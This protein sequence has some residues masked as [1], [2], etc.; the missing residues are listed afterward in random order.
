MGNGE[1]SG[2]GEYSPRGAFPP[3]QPW[4]MRLWV[5]SGLGFSNPPL[6]FPPCGGG[7]GSPDPFLKEDGESMSNKKRV[8]VL[9]DH[10]DSREL[11]A[12][13]LRRSGFDVVAY[14][15]CKLAEP[16]LT[17]CDIDIA[18]LDVRMPERCGDDF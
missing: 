3:L 10:D 7:P 4:R 9:E 1:F 6:S 14:A 8:L 5:V 16:H 11:L 18:L 2:A 17:A 12:A 13:L 15:A